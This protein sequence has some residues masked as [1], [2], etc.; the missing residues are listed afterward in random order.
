MKPT[1]LT[2]DSLAV[3][4]LPLAIGL[5]IFYVYVYA[6]EARQARQLT[7]SQKLLLRTLRLLV[8]LLCVLAMVRP[9]VSMVRSET[10]LPIVPVVI[11]EFSKRSGTSN[12]N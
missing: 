4:L 1:M 3:V 7:G 6:K 12:A 5:V 2:P 8:A 11:D 9:A 10:R